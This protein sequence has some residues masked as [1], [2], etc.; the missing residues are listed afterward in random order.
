SRSLL[1]LPILWVPAIAAW[2]EETSAQPPVAKRIDKVDIVHGDRRV[3]PYY[4]LREKS[5][6]EVRQ[7]LE[8]ENAYTEAVMKRT[9][10]LK[11]KLYQEMLARIQQTDASVPYRFGD[12]WYYHRDEEGKQYPIH[13]RRKGNT[14]AP[15]EIILDENELAK[16]HKYFDVGI[17][18]VSNDA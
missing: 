10:K 11:E 14:D 7:Y 8:A 4:W 6:P 15:E 9:E 1:I 2:R 13:C 16:D 3:D 17:L 5:N 12:Y 18:Q